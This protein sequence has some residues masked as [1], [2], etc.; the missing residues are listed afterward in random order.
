MRAGVAFTYICCADIIIIAACGVRTSGSYITCINR[1]GV[2]II[3][4]HRSENTT[5]SSVADIRSAGIIVIADYS[6]IGAFTI[7]ACIGCTGIFIIAINTC[8]VVCAI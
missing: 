8:A 7:A 3:T 6:S 2:A 1:A 5:G 4:I